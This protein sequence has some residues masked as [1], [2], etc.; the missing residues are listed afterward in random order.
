MTPLIEVWYDGACEPK[1]PGGYAAYGVIIKRG[2]AV[3]LEES[4]LVGVGPKMSNNVAEYS[5]VLRA[6]E[7]M[8]EH[9]MEKEKIL[10]RGDNKMS[11]MQ[12]A[13]LWKIATPTGLY[14]PYCLAARKLAAR[15]RKIRFEW[16]PREL[17]GVADEI[18]KRVLHEN[19][20]RFRIQ[21]E[22]AK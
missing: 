18:S 19:G 11:V 16:I 22:E 8:S 7:W 9:G 14:V 3:L 1:N 17:N 21:P 5:G 12:L 6:L 4:K 20:V 15:F 2:A 13:G 10:V